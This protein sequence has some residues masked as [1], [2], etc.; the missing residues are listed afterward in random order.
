[1][2][3]DL[4]INKVDTAMG[5]HRTAI[6]GQINELS[7]KT[8]L[9]TSKLG[10]H[11]SALAQEIDKLMVRSNTLEESI[12]IQVENL[13]NVAETITGSNAESGHLSCRQHNFAA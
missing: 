13:N 3:V 2:P 11:G 12:S 7:E 1:M 10:T 8:D 6:A 4:Q 5:K 9:I